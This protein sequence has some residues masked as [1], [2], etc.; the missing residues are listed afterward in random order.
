[1][2]SDSTN[3]SRLKKRKRIYD[4]DDDSNE[5]PTE[6][7]MLPA[8]PSV[9]GEKKDIATPS[10]LTKRNKAPTPPCSDSDSETPS[11]LGISDCST[12]SLGK[13]NKSTTLFAKSDRNNDRH[14]VTGTKSVFKCHLYFI[15]CLFQKKSHPVWQAVH[16]PC[17]TLKWVSGYFTLEEQ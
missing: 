15:H 4:T 14:Q 11:L 7:S 2:E 17:T 16:L 10:H 3:K 9:F 13:H 6:L 5:S 8:V 1:M 12:P